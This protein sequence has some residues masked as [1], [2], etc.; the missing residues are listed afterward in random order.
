MQQGK[1]NRVMSIGEGEF[2]KCACRMLLFYS[3]V[4]SGLSDCSKVEDILFNWVGRYQ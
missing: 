1:G 2:I 4:H 3:L